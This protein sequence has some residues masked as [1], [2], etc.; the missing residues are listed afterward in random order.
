MGRVWRVRPTISRLASAP[1]LVL[2]GCVHA[3]PL[4]QPPEATSLLGRPLREPALD[5]PTLAR[6]QQELAE[7]QA[8][9]DGDPSREDNIIWLGRRLAYLGR[10]R[11]AIEVFT[12]GL[13]LHPASFKLLRHRGH[14][15]I[16]LRRFDEAL[17]DLRRAAELIRGV[18]DEVEPDG[19]PN[20]GNFPT[21]TS[22]TNIYYHLGLAG[23][24]RGRFG[25]A[26]EAYRHCLELSFNDDMRCA[27]SY[28]LYLSLRRQ[29]RAEEAEAV[30]APIGPDQNIIEN[31][32]YHRLLLMFKGEISPDDVAADLNPSPVGPAV[33]G[34]TVGYGL[35]A[36]H[37]LN[38]RR[39]AALDQFKAVQASATW[40]AFGF[41][42]AEA[43]IAAGG[44]LP[45]GP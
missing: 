44:L 1:L 16:T 38:G 15:F 33:D 27:A 37:L 6:R 36:W 21:G 22:H 2:A 41:I 13:K 42:A 35:G 11:A 43:E 14:R 28:W 31:F 20:A 24:L 9:Y 17:S 18:P 39:A 3:P 12:A 10:F 29:G 8:A 5:A 32:A 4:S 45:E 25:E 34:A 26:A 23:F 40:P 30:L 7:A 19:L